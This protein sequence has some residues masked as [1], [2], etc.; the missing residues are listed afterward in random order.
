M[1]KELRV[2]LSKKPHVRP[3]SI[4]IEEPTDLQDTALYARHRL[5]EVAE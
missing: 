2:Y 1:M 3:L 4:D 5:Q